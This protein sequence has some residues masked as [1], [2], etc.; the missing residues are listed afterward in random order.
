[1]EFSLERLSEIKSVILFGGTLQVFVTGA[2]V[3]A[4]SFYF[5]WGAG[6]A[7]FHGSLV[8]L[9]STAIVIK[10]IQ[11][12]AL[13]EKPHGIN[14]LG[15]LIYQDIIIVPLLLLVPVI[16]GQTPDFTR[17]AL[18]QGGLGLLAAVTIIVLARWAVPGLLE[19]VVELQDREILL[20]TVVF[21]VLGICWLTFS[22]GLSLSLGAFVSGL[23]IS[24]SEHTH[25]VLEN[26]LPFRDVFTGLFFVSVGMSMNAATILDKPLL[27]GGLCLGVVIL[28]TLI[29]SGSIL[30]LGYRTSTAFMVGIMLNQIGEFSLLLSK[31]GRNHGLLSSGEHQIFL[32]VTVLTMILTPFEFAALNLFE[33]DDDEDDEPDLSSPEPY[34]DL[35][36]LDDHLIIVGFGHVGETAVREMEAL[37][38]PYVI[39]ELNPFTVEEQRRKDRP[40]IYGDATRETVLKE[41]GIR[42]A[43]G[44]LISTGDSSSAINIA[45]SVADLETDANL[46]VRVRYETQIEPL[47]E[48]NVSEIFTDEDS[49]AALIRQR[50]KKLFNSQT[51]SISSKDK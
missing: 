2:I 34:P 43:R 20:L 1:M 24:E 37:G 32:A 11:N 18:L 10:L 35:E 42:S 31:V 6:N 4:I 38:E 26:V 51:E 47:Q 9:S 5:G 45:E 16:S 21:L 29:A 7:I 17:D 23:I 30:A 19:F 44:V 33:P 49:V 22:V 15:I 13:L 48:L 12:N 41:A 40:I 39:I 3:F 27:I 8:A 36:P 14:S 25:H 46:L 50:V 28:K